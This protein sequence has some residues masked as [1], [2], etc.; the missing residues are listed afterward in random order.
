MYYTMNLAKIWHKNFHI[1]NPFKCKF[2]M[3]INLKL[4]KI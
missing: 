3:Y 2:N 4:L 1:L